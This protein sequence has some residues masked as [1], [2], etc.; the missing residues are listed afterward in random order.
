MD[1]LGPKADWPV[2]VCGQPV[3]GHSLMLHTAWNDGLGEHSRR[4][5]I[6][7][8]LTAPAHY[9]FGQIEVLDAIMDWG[10]NF[11]RG[12]VVKYLARAG[13]KGSEIEDLRKARVYLD[14][15]I[16]RLEKE[17]ER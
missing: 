2:C 11:C 17:F 13:R 16:A 8:S 7:D 10:L 4:T 12:N 5:R 14:R 9:T 3:E 6:A 1:D 15:E